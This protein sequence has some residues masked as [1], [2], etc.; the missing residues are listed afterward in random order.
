MKIVQIPALQDNYIYLIICEK[1]G[2]A[3]IV[4]SAD[5]PLTRN[6]AKKNNVSIEAIFNT[7]HHWDHAGGNSDLVSKKPDLKVFASH[8]DKDRIDCVTKTVG[9]GDSVSIGELKFSVMDIP[10]HTLGHIAYYGNGVLFCGDTLF[11]SGCGRLFEGTPAQMFDS[12]SKIKNLPDE[13]IVYCAH[14]YSQS[15]LKF[16]LTLEPSNKKLMEKI[17]EVEAKRANGESTVPTTLAEEL[18]YN[19]FLRWDAPELMTSVIKQTGCGNS[20]LE[21]FTATRKLKDNF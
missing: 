16:A 6:T 1:T 14:E 17:K 2:Q 12:L 9:E 11:V 5:A 8:Y 7:H 13:T 18:S 4:D 19:P 20:P 15:N 21:I 3:A 10:G